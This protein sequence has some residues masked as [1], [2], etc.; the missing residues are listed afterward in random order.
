MQTISAVLAGVLLLCLAALPDAAAETM[1]P[2]VGATARGRIELFGKRIPLPPGE[3][4]VAAGS[5]GYVTGEDHGPYGTIGNVLLIR[6]TDPHQ[7]SAGTQRL[8]SA[9]GVYRRWCV[10]EERRRAARSP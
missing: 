1:L 3:W 10:V 2:P 4:R 9:G 5:F 7:R 6:S 8:G